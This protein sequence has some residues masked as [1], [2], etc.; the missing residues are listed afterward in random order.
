MRL[1]SGGGGGG[2][3]VGGNRGGRLPLGM[4]KLMAAI[5]LASVAFGVAVLY[6][7]H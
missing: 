7:Y 4:D 6:T 1:D 2:G 5:A 3:G